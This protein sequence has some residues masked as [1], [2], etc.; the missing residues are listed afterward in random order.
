MDYVKYDGAPDPLKFIN[1]G[2]TYQS[3]M[4]KVETAYEGLELEDEEFYKV[5]K[6]LSDKLPLKRPHEFALI[7]HLVNAKEV[8]LDDGIKVVNKYLD[9]VDEETVI[10]A[11][12]YLNQDFY[13][14][15]QVVNY[16]KL[17]NLEGDKL[18]KLLSFEKVLSKKSNKEMILDLLNYG[19]IRY[20]K[21]YGS[22]NFGMPFFKLYEQYQMIDT[23]LL[24]NYEKIH[25][26]FRGSGLITNG[27]EYFLFVDLHKEED[28]KESINYKDEFITR[29]LFQWESPNNTS[30]SSERGMN[31]IY[32]KDRGVNLH[33]F[34]RKYKEIDGKVQPYIY[35]GKGD[36]VEFEGEKP[37]TIKLKLENKISEN[38]YT[39][40]VK[41]V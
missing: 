11:F 35:I 16:T 5:L 29:S 18:I 4:K 36:T 23:A 41:K 31:I 33:L 32:N 27:K 21:R 25:S 12:R 28:I 19:L 40:F 13:D 17:F 10:H 39:E 15:G 26:S 9:T 8:S 34:V 37:I 3:F 24:S 1:Y 38:L 7:K 20:E 30:Q 14:K 2:K 22:K 6:E